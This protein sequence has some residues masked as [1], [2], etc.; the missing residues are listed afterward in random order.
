MSMETLLLPTRQRGLRADVGL[1][2]QPASARIL[3]ASAEPLFLD[4]LETLVG[5]VPDTRVVA[6]CADHRSIR[7]DAEEHRPD[8]A[9]LDIALSPLDGGRLVRD[10][11]DAA[12]A[13]KLIV[14]TARADR[15]ALLEAACLGV[16][17]VL[18]KSVGPSQILQCIRAVRAGGC[19]PKKQLTTQRGAIR[20]ETAKRSLW[21]RGL[22]PLEA[23]VATLA[24]RGLRNLEIGNTLNVSPATVKV[25]LYR[26]YQKLGL[27]GRPAL[28][29]YASKHAR[30][31]SAKVA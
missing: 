3:I 18:L 16:R 6:R 28:I 10:L 25:R 22:T 4:G 26:V 27:S 31:R 14:F 30:V 7:R 1:R 15:E 12:P 20:R 9:L 8:V 13:M 19:W 17:G 5:R 11:R 21:P 2:D 29:A 24:G 23:E